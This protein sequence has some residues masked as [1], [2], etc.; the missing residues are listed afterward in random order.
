MRVYYTKSAPDLAY[1]WSRNAVGEPD[2][3]LTAIEYAANGGAE[4]LYVVVGPIF[5][6]A[7]I[8]ALVST[9]GAV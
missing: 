8:W 1:S 7:I 5:W 2:S 9:S 4:L 6:L 3:L